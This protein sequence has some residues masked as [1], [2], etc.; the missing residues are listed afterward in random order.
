MK[1]LLLLLAFLFVGGHAQA[2]I[3][4]TKWS[5]N[6]AVP[7]V[8]SVTLN[9]KAD[10]FEVYM[11]ENNEL[12][13]SMSYKISGDTLLLKK[14]SGGSPCPDGSEFKLKFSIKAEQ[15]LLTLLS[16]DCVERAAAW[17]NEP[18]IKIKE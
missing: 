11:L 16:D 14:A 2:Q 3:A 13:E 17:T 12:L 5:G 15:L 6:L 4:N 1:H 9:F 18:F 10:T 8:V 7:E